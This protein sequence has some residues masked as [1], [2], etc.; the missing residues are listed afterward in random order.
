[1]ED[2]YTQGDGL[3][4]MTP[5]I[6]A[7]IP[8]GDATPIYRPRPV[9]NPMHKKTIEKKIRKMLEKGIITPSDSPWSFGVIIVPKKETGEARCVIDLRPLNKLVPRMAYGLPRLTDC[10]ESLAGQMYFSSI[11]ITDAFF[12]IG[13][14]DASAQIPSFSTHM[15]AFRFNRLPQGY[16]NSP[17]IFMN[18]IENIVFG[19]DKDLPYQHTDKSGNAVA[20]APLM[21]N[22]LFAYIDDV[23]VYSRTFEDHIRDCKST[24]QRMRKHNLKLKPS[25]CYWFQSSVTY[26]WDLRLVVMVSG[27]RRTALRP[28][29]L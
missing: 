28:L 26:T 18:F 24:L 29:L 3:A 10:G 12:S 4:A 21:Y 19:L 13:L 27:L 11:D 17:M 9:T 2:V 6:T 20:N 25:K 23:L 22:C 5:S 14:D 1:M 16:K 7:N 8:V 15:G